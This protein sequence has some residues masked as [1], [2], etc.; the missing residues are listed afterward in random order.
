[1]II[2]KSGREEN[3]QFLI[4]IY[5]GIVFGLRNRGL[6]LDS[7][8]ADIFVKKWL[9]RRKNHHQYNWSHNIKEK[10]LPLMKKLASSVF[11]SCEKYDVPVKYITE[12][13]PSDKVI[14]FSEGSP[15]TNLSII[16]INGEYSTQKHRTNP[17]LN[18]W[19]NIESDDS[20]VE[21]F[22]SKKIRKWEVS[23]DEKKIDFN[24]PYGLFAL[25]ASS[26]VHKE[27]TID[28]M[29]FATETQTHIVFKAHPCSP[30]LPAEHVFKKILSEY[31]S[32]YTILV[33]YDADVDYLI[34]N[35]DF[36]ISP[37]SA[38]LFNALVRG[39]KASSY[40]STNFSELI[41]VVHSAHQLKNLS[42]PSEQDRNKF[43]TWYRDYL[44]IDLE[45]EDYENRID[46]RV[47]LYSEGASLQRILCP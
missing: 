46:E 47:R 34:D 28:A 24:H 11:S 21:Y 23:W 16:T 45:R 8:T 29:K 40:M 32:E 31:V 2:Q 14:T 41:P 9:E 27:M 38:V 36:V 42:I 30:S 18:L 19:K 20:V 26:G 10:N 37:D 17:H 25:Q 33:G 35:A 7:V 22:K 5:Y 6:V 44:C 12:Y 39:K 13:E 15:V 4:M 43:L 1:M 3:S